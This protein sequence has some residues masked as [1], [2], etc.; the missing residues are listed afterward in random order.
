MKFGTWAGKSDA[1]REIKFG[2][3]T[4]IVTH[5]C[6]VTQL[7]DEREEHVSHYRRS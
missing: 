7:L 6:I 2:T 5:Y 3:C 4:K 1:K